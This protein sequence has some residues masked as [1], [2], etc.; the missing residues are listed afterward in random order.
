MRLVNRPLESISLA[1]GKPTGFRFCGQ[2]YV[3]TAIHDHWR[4]YPWWTG[5][6]EH[7]VYRV[8]VNGD[9]QLWE[10]EQVQGRWYVYAI[11]D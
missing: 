9:A 10:I 6:G 7:D 8:F 2:S 11:Y 5:E 3:V 1:N 4:E